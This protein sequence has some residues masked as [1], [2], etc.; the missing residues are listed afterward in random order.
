MTT[1]LYVPG[2]LVNVETVLIDVGT[3]YFVRKSI[4]E[5]EAFYGRKLDYLREN[6]DK[7]QATIVEKQKQQEAI[8]YVLQAKMAAAAKA[9]AE[10]ESS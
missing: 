7:L 1:S 4:P 3:G 5:A 6:M 2:E 10:A 8:D 9:Q